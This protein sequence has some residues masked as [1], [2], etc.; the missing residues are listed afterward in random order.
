MGKIIVVFVLASKVKARFATAARVICSILACVCENFSP[1]DNQWM[2]Q[3]MVADVCNFDR[4]I[5]I[6]MCR[7]KLELMNSLKKT[8]R[9]FR[10]NRLNF[11]IAQLTFDEYDDSGKFALQNPSV[12][13]RRI[14]NLNLILT[15][16]ALS[17]I[18][19]LIQDI[20][21][22]VKYSLLRITK[23]YTV[24]EYTKTPR[25]FCFRTNKNRIKS[26]WF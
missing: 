3:T 15:F 26:C 10:A 4:T 23:T 16:N 25:Q 5:L 21:S 24:I 12:F 18:F 6:N 17:W 1:L 7:A 14:E 13:W 19:S 20:I 8:Y 9:K 11:K 2:A 22:S